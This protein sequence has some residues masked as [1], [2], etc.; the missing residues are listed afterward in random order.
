MFDCIVRG[1]EVLDGTGAPAYRADLG[2]REGRIVAIGDLAGQAAQGVIEAGGRAVA[3]GFI[4][5]HSHDD[6]NLPLNP[7]APGKTLQGVTTEVTGNCGF[8]PA[9]VAP[10]RL[11]LLREVVAFLDTGLAYSWRTFAEF[12]AALPPL[13][14]NLVPLVGHVPVRCAA[15]GM[16][17]RPPQPAELARMEALVAEAMGAGA[18]GFS[19]GLIYAPSCYA[20]TDELVALAGVAARHGGG[21]FTHQRDEAAGLLGS[22]REAIEIGRRSGAPVQIA[23]LKVLNRPN[24]GG[25]GRALALLDEARSSGIALHADQY[26]YE[27]SSTGLKTLLPA[28]VHEGGVPALVGR[29]TDATTRAR[30]RHELLEG[31]A[32]GAL[33]AT[34]WEDAMVSDSP[35]RPDWC[36]Q[37]LAALGGRLGREPVDLLLELI[38]A[39]RART[40]G[41]FF[42]IGEDDLRRILR[43][44]AIAI[45]S[46]GICLDVPGGSTASKPHPRHCGT[47]ARVLG[48]YGREAGELD[49]PEAVRKMTGLPAAILGLGDRGRIAPGHAADLVVFDPATVLDRAT[50][51]EPRLPPLGI[52][53]VVVNG[54]EVVRQGRHTGATPGTVLRKRRAM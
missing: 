39:D 23:H 31:F 29:L 11:P 24:W 25:A 28:W 2:L 21:Y 26:P 43:H 19:T 34:R 22:M 10:E 42:S 18:F 14:V 41:V 54:V 17:D 51:A 12:L 33:R 38:E 6:F 52:E 4:D 15:M 8:S 1:G 37:T 20:R 13:A 44:P 3:P 7:A 48:H 30:I 27:A 32:A 36:G 40:L 47:F 49:L 50:Y 45:G 5:I 46:D 16:D 53:T 9:P 35:S